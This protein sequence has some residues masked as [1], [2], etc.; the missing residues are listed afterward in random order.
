MDGLMDPKWET[1]MN[2]DVSQIDVRRGAEVSEG[3]MLEL[4]RVGSSSK[5]LNLWS[6]KFDFATKVFEAERNSSI[7][8]R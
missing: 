8:L 1:N 7:F 2:G 5:A 4:R 6:E 3:M